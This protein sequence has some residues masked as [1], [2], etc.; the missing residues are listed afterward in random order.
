LQRRTAITKD[1][2]RGDIP[3]TMYIVPGLCQG[4]FPEAFRCDPPWRQC[5]RQSQDNHKTIHKTIQKPFIKLRF[6]L[7]LSNS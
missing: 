7:E 5:T 1:P 2:E 3:E 4:R 6:A